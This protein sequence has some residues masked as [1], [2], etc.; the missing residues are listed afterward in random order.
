MSILIFLLLFPF[1]LKIFNKDNYLLIN[2]GNIVNLR[3]NLLV[4]LENMN[5]LNLKRQKKTFNLL[6]KIEF[7]ELN[8]ELKGLNFDYQI[9]GAYYG[10]IHA[11]FGVIDSFLYYRNIEFD[12]KLEY[13][14]EKSLKFESFIKEFSKTSLP[15][16]Y[17]LLDKYKENRNIFIFKSR[18]DADEYLKK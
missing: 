2:L 7:K 14:G 8:V 18:E 3:L 17:E 12:Y 15:K 1:K 9:S 13:D 11:L 5:Q 16:I 10:L 6:Q 4:L